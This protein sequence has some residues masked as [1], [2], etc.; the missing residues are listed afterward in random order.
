MVIPV[1][2]FLGTLA[3]VMLASCPVALAG[4]PAVVGPIWGMSALHTSAAMDV[5]RDG[6]PDVVTMRFPEDPFALD[7]GSLVWLRGRGDGSFE[8]PAVLVPTLSSISVVAVN[9]LLTL[10]ANDDGLEDL[11]VFPVHV[12]PALPG[13]GLGAPTPLP[14]DLGFQ[15]P[16]AA[17]FTSDGRLDL[18]ASLNSVVKLLVNRGDLGFDVVPALTLPVPQRVDSATGADVNA[19]GH[20]DLVLSV[21]EQLDVELRTLLG[22]GDGTFDAPVVT[23]FPGANRVHWLSPLDAD[24]DGATD[25]AGMITQPVPPTLFIMRGLGDGSFTPGAVL[26]GPPPPDDWTPSWFGTGDVNGDGQQDL[27]V[28]H[29]MLPP[30][31]SILAGLGDGSYAPA[32]AFPSSAQR[33]SSARVAD[34]N[35]D[36]RDDLI[37]NSASYGYVATLLGTGDGIQSLGGGAQGGSTGVRLTASGSTTPGAALSF[38]IHSS[39]PSTPALLLVGDTL[40][41]L[42]GPN[43]SYGILPLASKVVFTPARV[44]ARWPLNLPDGAIF[45]AQAWVP[46]GPTGITPSNVLALVADGN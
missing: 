42:L 43:G 35:G 1:R 6:V 18:V 28:P 33:I 5:D 7:E 24:A 19:D 26:P 44:T 4:D 9:T 12:L 46:G 27:L 45:Y 15:V 17:D 40:Q 39:A 31:L 30:R 13:G 14:P 16:V 37:T 32:R 2:P 41:P 25:L 29:R 3:A 11:V 38:Q 23:A 10:D 8:P 22:H 34:L 21:R 36:D 20:Q